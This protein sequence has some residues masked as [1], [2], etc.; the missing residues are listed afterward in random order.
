MTFNI[1]LLILIVLSCVLILVNKQSRV[2]KFDNTL[3]DN[4]TEK[5]EEIFKAYTTKT[6]TIIP[7]KFKTVVDQAGVHKIFKT[8]LQETLSRILGG[9][10]F[11]DS[12]VIRDVYNVKTSDFTQFVFDMDITNRALAFTRTL[13]VHVHIKDYDETMASVTG[14]L[15]DIRLLSIATV[16]QTDKFKYEPI[17]SIRSEP[18]VIKNRYN[19]I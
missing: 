16:A 11:K 10:Q 15:P 3:Y 19:Y 12:K 1:R 17:D 7:N 14:I 9:T 2:A 18:L 5:L 8:Y 6:D 4:E 13:R